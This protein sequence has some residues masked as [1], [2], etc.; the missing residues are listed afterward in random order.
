MSYA[1]RLLFTALLLSPLYAEKSAL[2]R[3]C[4]KVAA[5]Q[6]V[7]HG[8]LGL[9]VVDTADSEILF[10]YNGHESLKP[11]S[12]LKAITTATALS[13]LGPDFTFQ[14]VLSTDGDLSDDGL[15]EGNLL[16]KGGGDPS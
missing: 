13:L 7:K 1:L 12:S 5:S 11:A 16:I 2:E 9:A 6:D 14:T 8:S 15:L 3:A 10:L 4:D